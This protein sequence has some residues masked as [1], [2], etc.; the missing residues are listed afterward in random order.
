MRSMP[1]SPALRLPSIASLSCTR[2][3]RGSPRALSRHCAA[4]ASVPASL[5]DSGARLGLQPCAARLEACSRQGDT[6][7]TRTGEH[8]LASTI[9]RCDVLHWPP[10]GLG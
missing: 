3:K 7:L 10:M 1:S 2:A 8:D 4:V 9:V 6:L 5:K